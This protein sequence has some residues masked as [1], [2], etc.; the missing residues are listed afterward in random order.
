MLT[1]REKKVLDFFRSY[2]KTHGVMPSRGIAA[3][4]LG[5]KSR[6]NVQDVLVKLADKGHLKFRGGAVV[7]INGRCPACGK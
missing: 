7:E 1:P 3:E 2:S 5:L 4:A 6:G